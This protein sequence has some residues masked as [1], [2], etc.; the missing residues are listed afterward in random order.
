MKRFAVAAL[1]AGLPLLSVAAAHADTATV[2]V[3][4]VAWK[5]LNSDGIR[6]P[7]EPPL[8]GITLLVGGRVGYTDATGHYTVKVPVAG[9]LKATATQYSIEDGAFVLTRPH[10][11][12]PATDSDFDWASGSASVSQPPVDG[13]ID[14]V[15]VGYKP[16]TADPSVSLTADQAPGTAH[17]GDRISYT[18]RIAVTDTPAEFRV[19][20]Q[21]PDGVVVDGAELPGTVWGRDGDNAVKVG[22]IPTIQMPGDPRET[23]VTARIT[24][25]EV[26]GPV[27]ATLIEIQGKDVNP[28]NNSA[29]APVPLAG[30]TTTTTTEPTTTAPTTTQPTTTAPKASPVALK[31]SGQLAN[32]GADPTWPLIAGLALLAGG[33][34]TVFFARRRRAN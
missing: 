6:Q 16:S 4:G 17:V 23:Q 19:L 7:D 25:A 22:F 3:K 2:T 1:A 27:T 5:D 8:P 34:G 21:F 13:V 18:L 24:K 28:D 12:D 11:G 10:Q 32:T 26:S 29:S 20:V 9:T 14:N 33:V 31:T 30:A 15:D